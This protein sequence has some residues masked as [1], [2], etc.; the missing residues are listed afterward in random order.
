MLFQVLHLVYYS[1]ESG[2]LVHQHKENEYTAIITCLFIV[3]HLQNSEIHHHQIV[4]VNN[5][6]DRYT[7]KSP[8]E[9]TLIPIHKYNRPICFIQ[10]TFLLYQ[11]G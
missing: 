9:N 1:D 3:F 7:P 11:L 10:K 5:K 6:N 4:K 8:L 2:G